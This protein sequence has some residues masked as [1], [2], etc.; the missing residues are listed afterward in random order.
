MLGLGASHLGLIGPL[1][2]Q[3]EALSHRVEAIKSLNQAL[4]VPS[5]SKA[6]ADARFATFMVL[7]FQSTCMPDGL[8]DFLTM[9][10]GCNL[11]GDLGE[12]SKFSC[13]LQER[14]IE[15]MNSLISDTEDLTLDT[16]SFEDATASLALIRPLCG[17]DVEREYHQLL[18]DIV[19]HSYHSPK[20]G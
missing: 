18:T 16:K 8:I 12:D 17:T 9:L 20:R 6:E 10:R 19:E 13:F 15:T 14:H 11:S 3:S 1:D 2:L 7:T 4:S 5:R